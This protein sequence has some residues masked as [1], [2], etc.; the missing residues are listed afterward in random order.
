LPAIASFPLSA[1]STP[2]TIFTSVLLPAPFS[3]TSAC[4]VPGRTANVALASD[5]HAP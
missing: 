1:R 3:P 2:A 4:T 5:T